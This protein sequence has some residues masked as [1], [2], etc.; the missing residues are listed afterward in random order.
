MLQGIIEGM[1]LISTLLLILGF[2][3]VGIEFMAPGISAPGIG[4][5][6]SLIL[7][8]FLIADSV[9]EAVVIILIIL[10]ILGIMLGI[11]LWLFSK[12]KL[13]S[14]L[15]LSLSQTKEGGY[16]SAK[17]FENLLGKEG[18]AETDLR[19][20]G[21]GVFGKERVDVLSSGEY[22]ARQTPITV[23]KVEGAK[24]IV[25]KIKE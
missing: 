16:N 2:I 11:T 7:S 24:V 8:V 3:L 4:G 17:G 6:I 15:I 25:S 20:S 21:I 18:V 19:P 13:V 10:G 9:G 22:I 14:P 5:A 12:G 23:I 1:D